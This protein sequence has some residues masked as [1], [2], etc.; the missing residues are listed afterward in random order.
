MSALRVLHVNSYDRGGGA[1][2]AAVDLVRASR[3][4]G[5]ETWL[6]VGRRTGDAADVELLAEED[7]AL[8]GRVA[9]WMRRR[10][11]R[12]ARLAE[13]TVRPRVFLDWVLGHEP[14]DAPASRRLL[15][16][17][18]ATP[19]VVHVHNLHTAYF[20]LRAL[21][22]LSRRVPVVA[23]L[24]DAWLTTGHCAYPVTCERWRTGCGQCPDLRMP[25]EVRRDATAFNWRRKRDILAGARLHVAA[26]SRWL[27]DQAQG[28]ILAPAMVEE[29]LIPYGIDLERYRPGDRQAARAA[30]GLEPD[31]PLVLFAAAMART[32]RQKDYPTMEAAMGRLGDLVPGAGLVVLGEAAPPARIGRAEVLSLPFQADPARVVLHYQAADVVALAT[33]ADNLPLVVLEA[34]ACGRP[35]VAT[36]VGGLPEAVT[37]GVTGHL[38]P[39]G[40][41]DALARALGG[42]LLDAPRREAYGRAAREDAERRFELS[43]SVQRYAEWYR[44]LVGR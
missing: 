32:N 27:L 3:T 42:L 1:E 31:R 19:D 18:P 22:A 37:E 16:L 40:D 4:A 24:H 25:P 6:A 17:A 39:A 7:A 20:D 43:A 38:V 29:R 41:P 11:I 44:E 33:R 14:F 35:V 9:A 28:S 23:T 26:P 13:A 15:E 12:G 36:G 8:G 30:L 5:L 10:K 2:R 34:L 21:P